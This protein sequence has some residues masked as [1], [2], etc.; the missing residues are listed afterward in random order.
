MTDVLE[1]FWTALEARD[2]E[3]M[4]T[5]YSADADFADPVFRL[6]GGEIGAMWRMLMGDAKD[7]QVDAGSL[8]IDD[9]VGTGV[10]EATYTFTMTGRR[11]HN[12]I[13]SRFVAKDGFII[14]QRDSF[15]FWKWSRMA[16]GAKGTL[17]GWTPMVRRA[18][19]KRARKRL[20][21]FMAKTR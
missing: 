15:P 2:G 11:V 3:A 18:V 13:R 9:E 14:Q 17:L 4:A 12:R 16:L 5:C 21:S 10:W 8:V 7:L 19:Q 20:D 6:H 1:R